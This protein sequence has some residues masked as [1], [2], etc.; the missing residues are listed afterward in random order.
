L[1][2]KLSELHAVPP[3]GKT[4]ILQKKKDEIGFP[5]CKYGFGFI[6]W[7]AWADGRTMIDSP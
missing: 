6:A 7:G 3:F 5:D 4:V 2:A 1:P